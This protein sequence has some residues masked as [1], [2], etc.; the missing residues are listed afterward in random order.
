MRVVYLAAGAAGMICGSCLRDNRLVA[1]LRRQGRD[2][3]LIPLYTPLRTD[4]PDVSEPR[5]LFGGINVYLQQ[6]WGFFRRTPRFFDRLLDARALFDRIGKRASKTTPAQTGALAVSV[7]R[8]E[9][10]LQRKEVEKVVVALRELRPGLI[11]LPNLL[12]LGLA[13]RLRE[14][15]GAPLLCTLSGEDI[16]VDAMLEPHR[17]QALQLIREN[18][19]HVDGFVALTHY[20]ARYATGYFGL[21][22]ER[23]RVVP[24]GVPTAG[25]GTGAAADS[26]ARRDL[27]LNSQ[28]DGQP[29]IG[30]LARICP[31]KGLANLVA[32]AAG[33]RRRGQPVRL[34]AA[35]YLAEADRP[36]LERVRRQAA[37]A[38]LGADF[39]Y[40]GELSLQQKRDFLSSIDVFSVPS[41]Y[42]EAKG[43]SILE[44][45]AAGRPVV[46]PRHGSYPEIVE[47]TGGGVLVPPGDTEALVDALQQLLIDPHR[48]A[49]LGRLGQAGVRSRY[50]VEGMGAAAWREF[51][52]FSAN[53]AG[54]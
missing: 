42:P 19:A 11:N 36:Y 32:A 41:D 52:W 37:E 54:A 38:G 16:F 10:G 51:E 26:V 3:L 40:V 45:L 7:L 25:D 34:R 48:R 13:K 31:A 24:M 46:L 8:G 39:E 30:Y 14:A 21:P 49:E 6:R 5:V 1:T 20:Y 9:H 4:E 23:V 27:G 22:S 35:G 47:A 29:T 18:A 33:L 28:R 43:L 17:S 2:A 15:L 50:S 12:M 53:R 44:A